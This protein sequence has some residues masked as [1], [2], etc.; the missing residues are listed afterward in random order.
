[1][2]NSPRKKVYIP[3]CHSLPKTISSFEYANA[4]EILS[5]RALSVLVY[6]L[7]KWTPRALSEETI[8]GQISV[9]RD[10]NGKT[11]AKN[12]LWAPESI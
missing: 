4:Q 12:C 7:P 9:N 8:R 10:I 6:V 2:K 11:A 1:M 5:P 3:N